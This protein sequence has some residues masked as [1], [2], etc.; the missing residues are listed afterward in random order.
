MR[1][2]SMPE[3]ASDCRMPPTK[4]ST[5]VAAKIPT[6]IWFQ[7]GPLEPADGACAG[8]FGAVGAGVDDVDGVVVISLC[9]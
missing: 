9:G 8:G 6:R 1:S 2:G 7:D 4:P 5:P 3:L